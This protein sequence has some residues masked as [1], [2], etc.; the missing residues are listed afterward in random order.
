[1]PCRRPTGSRLDDGGCGS[2]AVSIV[3]AAAA[4]TLVAIGAYLLFQ[5]KLSRI[6]IGLGL[7]SHGANVLMIT[8]GDEG[9]APLIGN[10]DESSFA[11]PLPQALAL[12]A[13]VISFGTTALLLA[14]AYR[15]FVLTRDD[16]VVDDIEDRRIATKGAL[17]E[18][19]A[20]EAVDE[21]PPGEQ[22]DRA[23]RARHGSDEAGA[24]R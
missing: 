15:S 13:I 17:D 10:A 18:E 21:P 4:G 7:L 6:I 24:E 3:L 22:D 20:D 14:L 8:A 2:A 11:D 5:R 23:V 19:L 16:E 12:T 9:A 1:M